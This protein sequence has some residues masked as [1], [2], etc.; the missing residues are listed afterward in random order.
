[1]NS[2]TP[3][4]TAETASVFCEMLVFEYV[5]NR[6]SDTKLSGLLAGKIE[7]I[8]S[9]LY[10]QINFTTFERRVHAFEG[11]FQMKI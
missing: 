10:R 11:E 9:T 7:D 8:F 5:K 3:L 2:N 1:M 6:T 4:T